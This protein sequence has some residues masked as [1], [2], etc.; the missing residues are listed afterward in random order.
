M[1]RGE[2]NT[3]PTHDAKRSR[4]DIGRTKVTKFAHLAYS[5]D[6]TLRDF[7]LFGFLKRQIAEFT[8]RSPETI[9]SRIC[10]VSEDITKE[11][12]PVVYNHWIHRLE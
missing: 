6:A 5:P 9:L 4:P 10:R 12:F 1:L 3:P 11:T 8:A 7:F 2:L